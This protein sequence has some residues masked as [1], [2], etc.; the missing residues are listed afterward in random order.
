M[1]ED[2]VDDK[3]HNC[4]K[5]MERRV[6]TE[7]L[8]KEK[9]NNSVFAKAW[10]DAE[11]NP[12]PPGDN[13]TKNHSIAIY[14]YT[15][16]KQFK[17]NLYQEFNDAIR[18]GKQNYKDGTYLWYSLHFWLT[19]AIQILKKTQ[20]KCYDTYRG[21]NVDFDK[22]VKG[23]EVRFGQFASSSL[24][25]KVAQGP[26]FGSKSCFEIHT[27]SGADLTNYSM[28]PNQKEVL[29]PPYETFKVTGVKTK[30]EQNDLWCDTVFTLKSYKKRSFLNCAASSGNQVAFLNALLIVIIFFNVVSY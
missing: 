24:D 14:A 15:N 12:K 9:K 30:A 21:T 22:N 23:K 11:K 19:E 28:H 3:F 5:K 27:C 4:I 1:A 25:C 13:L 10:E 26:N 16:S 6:Q 29:I 20:T 8:N 2:S 7:F 17:L 18:T